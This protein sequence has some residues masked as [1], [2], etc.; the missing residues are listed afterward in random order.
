VLHRGEEILQQLSRKNT[1]HHNHQHTR[2]G[3]VWHSAVLVKFS[4]FTGV[5]PWDI[6]QNCSIE[7]HESQDLSV[8]RGNGTVEFVF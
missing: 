7:R 6:P 2:D 4:S 1:F 3:G 8:E 5:V